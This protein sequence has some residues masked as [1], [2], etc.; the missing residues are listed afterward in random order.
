[1]RTLDEILGACERIIECGNTKIAI[2]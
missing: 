2:C 1:M